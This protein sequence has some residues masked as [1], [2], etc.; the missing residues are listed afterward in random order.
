M[1]VERCG[2]E[3][4]HRANFNLPIVEAHRQ[5]ACLRLI[6]KRSLG[7]IN[8]RCT[9][10]KHHANPMR[11]VT[12]TSGFYRW[13]DL[14]K[15]GEQQPV[16]AAIVM[17]KRVRRREIERHDNAA[18]KCI[19]DTGMD[20]SHAGR[21]TG[22][23]RRHDRV[24]TIAKRV[25]HPHRMQIYAWPVHAALLRSDGMPIGASST[26][27]A[28]PRASDAPKLL[29]AGIA[30]MASKPKE[31][32]VVAADSNTPV[33]TAPRSASARAAPSRRNTA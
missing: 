6:H 24:D 3:R 11:A 8:A 12:L 5:L 20:Y 32:K 4:R 30:L 1:K 26:E 31:S 33:H 21:N 17:R 15:R 22:R 2:G 25:D 16:I 27:T 29:S 9:G 13:R 14:C 28:I 7:R 10:A 19:A 23:E 18:G